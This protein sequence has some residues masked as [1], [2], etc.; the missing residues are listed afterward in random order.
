MAIGNKSSKHYDN[1]EN[2]TVSNTANDKKTENNMEMAKK[3]T[4]NNVVIDKKNKINNVAIDNKS[5][6]QYGH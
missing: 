1:R 5:S 6:K 4:V 3:K 2:K